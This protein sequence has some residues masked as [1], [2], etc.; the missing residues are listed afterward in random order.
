MTV[1]S[2]TRKNIH[3]FDQALAIKLGLKPA[4]VYQHVKYWLDVNVKNERS[5]KKGR[6]W[7]YETQEDMAEFFGYLSKKEVRESLELLNKEGYLDREKLSENHFDQTWWYALPTEK[8]QENINSNSSYE[9]NKKAPSEGHFSSP[10]EGN[11]KAPSII[12]TIQD[13][14]KEQQQGKSASPSAVVF[15]EKEKKSFKKPVKIYNCLM[16]SPVPLLVEDMEEISARHLE[17][18]VVN[19]LA[20]TI[21]NQEKIK[22]TFVQYLKMCCAKKLKL[23]EKTEPKT[24][25]DKV[26]EI[27]KDGGQYNSAECILKKDVIAF[28]R[29]MKHEQLNLDKYF[30][31]SRLKELCKNFGISLP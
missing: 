26:K 28:Q 12:R 11:K 20:Y 15:P 19:G 25:Y 14:E 5:W 3:A 1:P 17:E 27:F 18:D 4:I 16:K 7:M 21:A 29:G 2:Y 24:N 22:T 31:W 6:V 9:S 10:S 13:K 8:P 23:S 30:T